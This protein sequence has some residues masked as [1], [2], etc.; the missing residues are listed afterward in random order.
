VDQKDVRDSRPILARLINC[1]NMTMERFASMLQGLAS[2]YIHA[3]VLDATGLTGAWD[4][5]LSFSTIG[6]LRGGP[7]RPGDGAAPPTAPSGEASDPNG[8]LSL[9]DAIAKQLG[10]RLEQTKRPVKVLVIDHVEQ[11]PIEN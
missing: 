8:A 7:G 5:T 3:P 1:Q 11:T 9:P 4:F 2:G 6:Q 10:L